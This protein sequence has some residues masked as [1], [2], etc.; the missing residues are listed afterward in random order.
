[1]LLNRSSLA[2]SSWLRGLLLVHTAHW[3]P[4]KYSLNFSNIAHFMARNSSFIELYFFSAHCGRHQLGKW[5]ANA[6]VGALRRQDF[7]WVKLFSQ[8]ADCASP[9]RDSVLFVSGTRLCSQLGEGRD[10]LNRVTVMGRGPSTTA[11]PHFQYPGTWHSIVHLY[12]VF[13]IYI[14]PNPAFHNACCNGNLF[15]SVSLDSFEL[16]YSF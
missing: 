10:D 3:W 16:S 1:M 15:L 8:S 6:K 7:H 4:H 2:D 14:F 5:R 13:Y 12:I 9:C 11:T